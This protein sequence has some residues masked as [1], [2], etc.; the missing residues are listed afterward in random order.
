MSKVMEEMGAVI[1]WEWDG[2]GR[3]REGKE[4]EVR[5]WCGRY[6]E[7][8]DEEGREREGRRCAGSRTARVEIPIFRVAMNKTICSSLRFLGASSLVHGI[9]A[10]PGHPDC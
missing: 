4:M 6:V 7:E 2:G 9:G 8:R 5:S 10:S 3:D 1:D